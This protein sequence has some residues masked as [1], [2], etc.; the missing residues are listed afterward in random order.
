MG[1]VVH[2]M[3]VLRDLMNANPAAE[4]DWLVEQ[5]FAAIPA[6][7]P[8]VR[9]VL[10]LS[11]RKW[12]HKLLRRQTWSAMGALRDQLREHPYELILDLQGLLKSALWAR[13]A[14]GPV[15]GF[16]GASAREPAAA[17]LYQRSAPVSASKPRCAVCTRR[18]ASGRR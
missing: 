15:A 6:L 5:P 14:I 8:A 7:H 11:W 12:R 3:P 9:R 2:A 4:V 18:T 10:P 16:D 13:Q 1:D 17:W